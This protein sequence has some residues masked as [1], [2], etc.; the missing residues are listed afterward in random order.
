M[1][2]RV[3]VLILLL[4]TTQLMGQGT[5]DMSKFFPIE[6]SHSYVGFSVKYMGYAQV[7]G[8]FESFQGTV[9]YDESD[10]SKTS[11]S[12]SLNVGSIDTDLDWR[13]RDLKSA[14]WFHAD[15]FP[16][17]TF[18]SQKVVAK[19]VGFDVMGDLTIKD[20]TKK[21][22]LSM[23]PASGVLQDA[24]GDSQV[25]FTG[26]TEI[27]RTAFDVQGKNWSAVREGITAVDK[28][29]TI[30]LSILAKRINEK[31]Y[32]NWVRN[33]NNPP[34]QYYKLINEKGLDVALSEFEKAKAYPDSKL[35]SGALNVVGYMLLREGKTEE[36]LQVFKKNMD[37]FPDNANVYDSY[38]E[39]LAQ[40]G[41]VKE[42]Q[43]HYQKSLALNPDNQNARE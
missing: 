16:K 3:N 17:I 23:D 24:R 1:N 7:R 37:L 21:V 10:I 34:G 42:A 26:K 11:I 38:A 41:Q 40:I 25:I 13:D 6:A 2:K 30:E 32:R 4:A 19:G 33:V 18:I 39:V 36:A 20:V 28:M 29:V 22:T 27:D 5:V 12:F 31:N 35:N 9:F 15:T 8:R 43:I 14:N